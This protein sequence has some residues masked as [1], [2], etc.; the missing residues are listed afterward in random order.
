V[1]ESIRATL[2]D[3]CAL[4]AGFFVRSNANL[5]SGAVVRPGHR[6]G[7][8]RRRLGDGR[9]HERS[10]DVTRRAVRVVGPRTRREGEESREESDTVPH[11]L[12]GMRETRETRGTS[13]VRRA[14]ITPAGARPAPAA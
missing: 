8:Q 7:E 13:S 12:L 9:D 6:D 14:G 4:A 10:A 3:E 2:V 5:T 11:G 1:T